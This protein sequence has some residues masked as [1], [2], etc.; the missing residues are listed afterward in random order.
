MKIDEVE[1]VWNIDILES[2]KDGIVLITRGLSVGDDMLIVV[3]KFKVIDGE[4][5]P[6]I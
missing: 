2:Y 6:M 3:R 5:V 4:I 1:N